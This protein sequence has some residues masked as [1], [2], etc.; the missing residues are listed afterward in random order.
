MTESDKP[1]VAIS[2]NASKLVWNGQTIRLQREPSGAYV[3]IVDLAAATGV[4][5][6]SYFQTLDRNTDLFSEHERSVQMN[7]PGGR[8]WIRCI[9]RDGCL[10]LLT[11]ISV[12]SVKSDAARKKLVEFQKWMLRLMADGVDGVATVAPVSNF[13]LDQLRK[14]REIAD[15]IIEMTGADR[16]EIY[17][18]VLRKCELEDYAPFLRLESSL[19]YLSVSDISRKI[20]KKPHEVNMFLYNHKL[21]II[22]DARPG[23]YRLTNAGRVYADEIP[24]EDLGNGH[25]G[26]MIRWKPLVLELFNVRQ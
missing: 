4:A 1:P 5:K 12:N 16:T 22:D 17:A 3:P 26:I 24:Y 20:G 14:E 10:M 7:T 25:K 6:K 21:Q 18:K 23:E 2:N 13:R 11:K 9:D 8:Q 15:Y 19:P